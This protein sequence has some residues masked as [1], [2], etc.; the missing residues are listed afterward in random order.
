[1]GHTLKNFVC[2]NLQIRQSCVWLG[3]YKIY[4]ASEANGLIGA[5]KHTC[6]AKSFFCKIF[7]VFSN[8]PLEYN[9]K[10]YNHCM[11]KLPL[12]MRNQL[13]YT[14]GKSTVNSGSVGTLGT[15]QIMTTHSNAELCCK[16]SFCR[17]TRNVTHVAYCIQ[18]VHVHYDS[19]H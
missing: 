10:F 19:L 2:S 5:H 7:A 9:T 14:T 4:C 15:Q 6:P 18:Y 1:M 12:L 13:K 17:L 3:Y 16:S 11:K 8:N